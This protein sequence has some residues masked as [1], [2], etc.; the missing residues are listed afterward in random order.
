VR[1]LRVAGACPC[2]RCQEKP[3]ELRLLGEGMDAIMQPATPPRR[4]WER[5][6]G[7]RPLHDD[8]LLTPPSARARLARYRDA[9]LLFPM[10]AVYNQFELREM[11]GE[12]Y[13]AAWK[14]GKR[15][16]FRRIQEEFS[17]RGYLRAV[18]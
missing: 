13:Q 7:L 10:D 5:L 12:R 18:S 17:P 3:L 2:V 11:L 6:F 16:N 14:Q 4:W 15:P 8:R 1:R 9:A